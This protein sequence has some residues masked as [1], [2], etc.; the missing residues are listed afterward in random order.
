MKHNRHVRPF[1]DWLA[2]QRNGH[3]AVEVSE[4]LNS[5]IEAV[6]EF[7]KSGSLTLAIKVAPTSKGDVVSVL[8]T[9][10]ITV[11]AP[12]G[13]RPQSVF[14][15]DGDA[16]LTR[17]NPMSPQLPLREVPRTDDEQL[18]EAR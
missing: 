1:A 16:N 2:E 17:Q 12:E 6:A 18:R 3:A 13:E 10:T 11:K 7:G 8:V 4:A 15:V 14:F 9:D 5:L